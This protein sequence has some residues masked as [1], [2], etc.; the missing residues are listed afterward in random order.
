[1]PVVHEHVAVGKRSVQRG[2]VRV[3]KVVREGVAVVDP[4]LVREEVV[5]ERV[6]LD[7]V[8]DAAPPPRHEGDT[9]VL[10][11][12]REVLVKQLRLV[13][14]VRITKRHAVGRRPMKVP[15]RR[16]EVIVERIA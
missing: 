15:L 5:V 14:E 2:K 3:R 9:L 1:V 8:V 16:E 4:P 6:S 12:V 13:E 7:R 10:P 11:V